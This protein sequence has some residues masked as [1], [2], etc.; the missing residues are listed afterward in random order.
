MPEAFLYTQRCNPLRIYQ[1]FESYPPILRISQV[2]FHYT[3][4]TN[5]TPLQRNYTKNV[6]PSQPWLSG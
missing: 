1:L 2:S 4:S 6:T 5:T 3:F